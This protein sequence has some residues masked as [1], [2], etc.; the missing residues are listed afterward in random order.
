M[1]NQIYVVTAGCVGNLPHVENADTHYAASGIFTPCDI[2]CARDG[3]AGEALPGIVT[4]LTQDP[5][6][7]LLRRARRGGTVRNWIDRRTDLYRVR[8][9]TSNGEEHDI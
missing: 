4:V 8:V 1:E 6:T 5:D 9:R 3:I 2:A 7:E